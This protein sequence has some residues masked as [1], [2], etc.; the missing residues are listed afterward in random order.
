MPLDD[1]N[2]MPD[3]LVDLSLTGA[4]RPGGAI[5]VRPSDFLVDELPLYDP[6]G[7]GEHLYLGIQ[8]EGMP[9]HEMVSVLCRHFGVGER[10]IGHAGM[11]DRHAVT[12]QM[13]S[14]H[15]PGREA[16]A[17]ELRHPRMGIIWVARHAN[18]LKR[19]HSLGNRFSIRL[20]DIDPLSAPV[21]WQRLRQ[22]ERTGVPDAFG[23]QRFGY[24]RNTHRLGRLLLERRWDDLVQELLGDS[25]SPF[26]E[27]Q[28]E[29]RALA[30]RGDWTASEPMWSRHDRHELI[31]L[32]ALI[33]GASAERAIRAVGQA[34]TELWTSALQSAVFNAV[35]ARR[36][37]QGTLASLAEGDI[38]CI[39]DGGACFAV[40]EE[41]LG[42]P[43]SDPQSVAA[44]LANLAISPTGPMH[45]DRMM[46]PGGDAA[47]AES[48]ACAAMGIEASLFASG[49]DAPKG[50]RRPLRV[51][52]RNPEIASGLDEHG[53]F[54]RLAFDLPP[55]AFAT[56]VL[57]ECVGPVRDASAASGA[58][59]TSDASDTAWPSGAAADTEPA[60]Q[61]PQSPAG[62]G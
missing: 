32:R 42:V 16:P 59:T 34:T 46:V 29:R 20:R 45:G 11:K 6:C 36:L 21:I 50:L 13:V 54:V 37:A 47:V 10:A 57:R 56:V 27:R 12:R 18:K 3:P 35:L 41:T 61:D 14:I 9:H 23:P 25:G 24:R 44:R 40:T 2:A 51:P 58:S 62:T 52:L 15:L 53:A 26:P 38:A 1:T 55:G 7:S 48:E 5:R 49:P 43:A 31:V 28:R 60:T 8:K 17:V 22:L 39:H 33:K 30:A 4:M 19:G